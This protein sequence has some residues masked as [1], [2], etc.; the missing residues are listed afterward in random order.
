M[1]ERTSISLARVASSTAALDAP[2]VP[3]APGVE[4]AG[5]DVWLPTMSLMI[6]SMAATSVP[7]FA[8]EALVDLPAPGWLASAA[9][10]AVDEP[11]FSRLLKCCFNFA[12]SDR[13]FAGIESAEIELTACCA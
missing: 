7:Q 1:C 9:V 12:R 13:F 8:L 3:V 2:L 10:G 5:D 11:I 4:V 6:L